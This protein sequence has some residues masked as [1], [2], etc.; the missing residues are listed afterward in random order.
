LLAFEVFDYG[1]MVRSAEQRS[2]R[3]SSVCI[4]RESTVE[5]IALLGEVIEVK[6]C[7]VAFEDELPLGVV[8][9]ERP[10]DYPAATAG[11]DWNN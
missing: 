11:Y 7:N 1:R 9:C 8:R 5:A 6:P 10:V 3:P 4:C 2:V